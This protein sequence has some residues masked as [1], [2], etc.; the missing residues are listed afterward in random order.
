M[1]PVSTMPESI[2]DIL[3]WNPLVHLI[4]TIRYSFTHVPVLDWITIIYP[5][6]VVTGFL[7]L[8]LIAMRALQ[9]RLTSA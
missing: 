9:R 6:V 1:F 8:G 2:Q 3:Y 5:L 7:F 4:T